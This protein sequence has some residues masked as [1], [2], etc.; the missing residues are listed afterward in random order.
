MSWFTS[1]TGHDRETDQDVRRFLR[2]DGTRLHSLANERTFECGRFSMPSLSDLR[3]RATS[4][5]PACPVVSETIGDVTKLLMARENAGAVFQVAS[6]FN[7]LEMTSPNITP[8]HGVGRYEN[9]KTQGPACAVACGAGTIYRN[10]F[11]PI[12]GSFGQSSGVQIDCLADVGRALEDGGPRYWTMMNGYARPVP[13][14]LK[15]LNAA[16]A[17][18]TSEQT[19]ELQGKLRVGMQ[20]GTEVTLGGVGHRV[21]QVFCSAMPVAYAQERDTL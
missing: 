10:Y 7:L 18:L 14:G 9:D 5:G 21:T 17:A 1:L 12:G 3:G 19:R 11:V 20:A 16:L 8:E 2:L 6:Q 13:G 4:D 15:R